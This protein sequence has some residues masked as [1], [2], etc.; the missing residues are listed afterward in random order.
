MIGERIS[1]AP[2]RLSQTQ[3]PVAA[4]LSAAASE[5]RHGL[6]EKSAWQNLQTRLDS[7]SASE[8]H[9]RSA[10]Q[11]S[12]TTLAVAA[13]LLL[14]W[15]A[16]QKSRPTPA[17]VTAVTST[18]EQP[19][20]KIPTSKLDEPQAMDAP[21]PSIPRPSLPGRGSK[22][23]SAAPHSEVPSDPTTCRDLSSA[24]LQKQAETCYL[25]IATGSGLS[26]EMALYEVAR[27]RR[28]VLAN[29]S[30]SLL[31][32]D[33]YEARFPSGTLAP[34]VRMARVD[35]LAHLGR[36]AEVLRTS[37]QLL[38]TPSGRA[39]MVELRL[40][41][42]NLLRDRMQDFT[43]AALEYQL[44]E[45]D[46]GPRGDQAQI[47]L[48]SCLERLGRADQAIDAYRRYLA[49]PRPEQA[50]RARERLKALLP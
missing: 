14:G 34:E 47:A 48:A 10:S 50:D 43:A 20:D 18:F 22:A 5:Y 16:W 17:L 25:S 46:P 31:A 11:H 1:P 26:A 38:A 24:G 27:L 21:A 33:E 36:V 29:P 39:R 28:D 6:D 12:W 40:L 30:A 9:S 42:G 37:D 8:R 7:S 45:S 4:L 2:L 3:G 19:L 15:V 32:L 49:R 23:G 13:S 44:I 35:L 41:R